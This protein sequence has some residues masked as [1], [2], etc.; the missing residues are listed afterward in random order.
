[1][2]LSDFRHKLS[3]ARASRLFVPIATF[4][5]AALVSIA[6]A[7]FKQ[8]FPVAEVC[9]SLWLTLAVLTGYIVF[10]LFVVG[11]IYESVR[12]IPRVRYN[13]NLTILGTLGVLALCR[14]VFCYF[15]CP[16]YL[17]S[18]PI[19]S[20]PC[21]LSYGIEASVGGL[22]I[23]A[24]LLVYVSLLFLRDFS[25]VRNRH[26]GK[27]RWVVGV[28]LFFL[29]S[30]VQ[31]IL[32]FTAGLFESLVRNNDFTLN[33]CH[34]LS[35]QLDSILLV[36][37]LFSL[38]FSFSV[39]YRRVLRNVDSFLN[40]NL[41]LTWIY[42][43][44]ALGLSFGIYILCTSC[45]H[46]FPLWV[47]L[48]L[49]SFY[50]VVVMVMMFYKRARFGFVNTIA[51]QLFFSL[52]ATLLLYFT[53]ADR[54]ACRR[55][56]F[57]TYL[58]EEDSHLCTRDSVSSSDFDELF[59]RIY[60]AND[61]PVACTWIV[62]TPRFLNRAMLNGNSKMSQRYSFGYFENG[63]LIDQYGKH[64]YK[65]SVDE[66]LSD[67]MTRYG[68]YI[69]EKD[70][71]KHYTYP[72]ASDKHIVVTEGDDVSFVIPAAFS[73]VFVMFCIYYLLVWGLFSIYMIQGTSSLSMYNRL[74]WGT[75]S[76][77]MLSGLITCVFTL[78]HYMNNMEL[79]RNESVSVKAGVIQMNFLR[80]VGSFDHRKVQTTMIDEYTRCLEN[81]SKSFYMSVNLYDLDGT[82]ITSSDS[83]ARRQHTD[84]RPDVMKQFADGNSMLSERVKSDNKSVFI[85][86]KILTDQKGR[87]CGYMS[88][89]DVKDHYVKQVTL[90]SLLSRYMRTYA[91]LIFLSLLF[92]F[93]VY[94]LVM[95][96][97]RRLGIALRRRPR[98][99]SPIRIDWSES[100][101][102]GR[103]IKEHNRAL[104]ELRENARLLAKSE[105]ET[106]W[107]E[108]AQEIAHEIKNP[109]TPMRLKVQML[110]RA[111]ATQRSDFGARL[112]SATRE[113]LNQIDT[114]TEVSDIFSEF[115]ST[116]QS[117]NSEQNLSKLLCRSHDMMCDN[118][119][120]TYEFLFDQEKDYF[121]S[122]DADLFIKMLEYLVKNSDHNRRED[123]RLKMVF[124]LSQDEDPLYWLLTVQANDRGLDDADQSLVFTVKF[125]SDN[126]G[127]SLCLPIVK[128]IVT[129]FGGDINLQTSSDFGTIFHIRIPKL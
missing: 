126:C 94:W 19:F 36:Y 120:T 2:T 34:I 39:L 48:S 23:D 103:L 8:I 65:T 121:A 1:M 43:V 115:A 74:L 68:Y 91:V 101:E 4:S 29:F 76:A 98:E 128:N 117:V 119:T 67:K 18:L 9:E 123:G 13:P 73:F 75:F 52:F 35:F 86:H 93:F 85:L 97:M 44:G 127:H 70:D 95:R 83:V 111:W 33:P 57:V 46:I 21:L 78:Y 49:A 125:S 16:P 14:F 15:H 7:V 116:Q 12:L 124:T 87:T 53:I 17:Y 25:I 27:H 59:S 56:T 118:P 82:F 6:L 102:I 84:L 3:S 37:L 122:V 41:G 11:G 63:R 10:F 42:V 24:S 71:A 32:F 5:S 54:D 104:E 112:E 114:L 22:T 30:F 50:A 107:R 129:G 47:L 64:W 31:F 58:L 96:S 80:T 38:C 99:N 110:E 61:L 106:A 109:L 60:A 108:M 26:V 105:R 88:F 28:M 79:V 100:E 66:Y 40:R 77:L 81:L 113:V 62:K 92:S 45:D 55:T 72:I 69:V 89:A 20:T 51:N 90:S